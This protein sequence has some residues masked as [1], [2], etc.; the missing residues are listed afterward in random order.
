MTRHIKA[1]RRFR[2]TYDALACVQKE[3]V[4][5]APDDAEAETMFLRLEDSGAFRN[6]FEDIEGSHFEVEIVEIEDIGNAITGE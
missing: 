1:N 4:I 6:T 2:I 3:L 5:M